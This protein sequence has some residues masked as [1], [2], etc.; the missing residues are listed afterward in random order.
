MSPKCKA[1]A[2]SATDVFFHSAQEECN[3]GIVLI[4][5]SV[6]DSMSTCWCHLWRLLPFYT[7]LKVQKPV[8]V[9]YG[10][11]PCSSATLCSSV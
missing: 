2:F 6:T 1:S 10:A 8:G 11:A 7:P 5:I 3:L 9:I 4:Q